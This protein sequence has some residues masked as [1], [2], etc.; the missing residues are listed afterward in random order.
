MGKR[1]P[2]QRKSASAGLQR[3]LCK[4]RKTSG[5]FGGAGWKR[6]AVSGI[7]ALRHHRTGTPAQNVPVRLCQGF[8]CRAGAFFRMRRAEGGEAAQALVEGTAHKKAGC[9]GHTP[10]SRFFCWFLWDSCSRF[11]AHWSR[12]FLSVRS[13][14]V[15]CPVGRTGLPARYGSRS[16]AAGVPA[17]CPPVLSSAPA[18]PAARTG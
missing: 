9:T 10:R 15:L 18:V 11:P 12:R 16:A 1:I 4:R 14:F 8:P 2:E 7:P 17:A 6:H 13:R 5:W 3:T